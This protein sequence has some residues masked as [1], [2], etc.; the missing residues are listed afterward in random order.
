MSLS[1]IIRT[2]VVIANIALG[3]SP[4]LPTTVNIMTQFMNSQLAMHLGQVF[5]PQLRSH[6]HERISPTYA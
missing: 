3:T 2:Y 1:Q 4:S 6:E 5:G